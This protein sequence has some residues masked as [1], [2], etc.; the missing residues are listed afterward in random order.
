M[1]FEQRMEDLQHDSFVDSKLGNDVGEEKVTMIASCWID[2]VFGEQTGPGI[3]HQPPQLV[4]LLLVG[5]I[6]NMS[7]ALVHQ[8]AGELEQKNPDI[9]RSS[10]GIVRVNDVEDESRNNVDTVFIIRGRRRP[11]QAITFTVFKAPGKARYQNVLQDLGPQ[12]LGQPTTFS[13]CRLW[14]PPQTNELEKGSSLPFNTVF[15]GN[16]IFK[17][18]F[19]E[20]EVSEEAATQCTETVK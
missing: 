4:A 10:K 1:G 12:I 18:V 7:C 14:Q 9:V 2:T 17:E 5:S 8:K 16:L 15:L 11:N 19:Q 13:S 6:V 3:C 20:L